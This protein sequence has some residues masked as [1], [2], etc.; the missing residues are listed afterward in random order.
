MSSLPFL[1]YG[2]KSPFSFDHF[3]G[4]CKDLIP[5]EDLGVIYM[6][7][8]SAIYD[9]DGDQGTLKKWRNFEMSLRNEL[10]KIRTSRRHIDP[11]PYLRITG[12]SDISI[13]HIA[14]NAHRAITPLESEKVL[15]Q[16]RWHAL[17]ELSFGHYFDIASLIIYGCKLMIL[18]KQDR[19]RL[20]NNMA[21]VEKVLA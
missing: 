17:E 19:I 15:D 6:L 16:A 14:I 18:E 21:T 5:D 10:V 12:E 8:T 13:N 2:E 11:E 3:L 1:R 9:Y 7:G 4:M 20:A